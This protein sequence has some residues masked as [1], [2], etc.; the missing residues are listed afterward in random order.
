MVLRVQDRVRAVRQAGADEQCPD[1][2][3]WTA[4][5]KMFELAASAGQAAFRTR[6]IHSATLPAFDD[7]RPS[8]ARSTARTDAGRRGVP[9]PA[10]RIL[11]AVGVETAAGGR[12]AGRP[13][14]TGK[15]RA[16]I[17][18]SMGAK[19]PAPGVIRA[20]RRGSPPKEA[21]RPHGRARPPYQRAS[22]GRNMAPVPRMAPTGTWR[23]RLVAHI[24]RSNVYKGLF[25]APLIECPR[26]SPW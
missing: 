5:I 9:G 22:R 21:S 13:R 4:L 12:Q 15:A 8:I 7:I 26:Q 23:P 18:R 25:K 24:R 20:A 11:A 16:G 19:A 17:V 10:G 3:C 1:R 6:T 2:L 14:D